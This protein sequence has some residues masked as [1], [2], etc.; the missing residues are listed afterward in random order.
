MSNKKELSL[1]IQS[2][3]GFFDYESFFNTYGKHTYLDFSEQLKDKPFNKEDEKEYVFSN[4]SV[5]VSRY[6]VGSSELLFFINV[7]SRKNDTSC[8][9]YLDFENMYKF[10]GNIRDN[11]CKLTQRTFMVLS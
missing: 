7:L 6:R 10:I 3:L 1:F 11:S 4:C 9:T 8:S 5:S 2:K